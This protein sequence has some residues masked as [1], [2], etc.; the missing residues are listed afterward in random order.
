MAS[1]YCSIATSVRPIGL[2]SRTARRASRARKGTK[3]LAFTTAPVQETAY[4]TKHTGERTWTSDSGAEQGT[5]T[6]SVPVPLENPADDPRLANPL[7][8]FERLGTGWMGVVVDLEGVIVREN[9]EAHMT[10]WQ[11]LSDEERR[12]APLAFALHRAI[13]KKNEQVVSEV[14]CWTRDPTEVRRLARRKH[15]LYL[16]LLGEGYRYEELDGARHLLNLLKKHGVPVAIGSSLPKDHID[17]ILKEL[18]LSSFFD[19]VVSGEDVSRGRPDPECYWYASQLIERPTARCIVIGNDNSCTEAAHDAGMKCVTVASRRP[20]Y[21]LSAADLVVR[22]LDELSLI[23]LKALFSQEEGTE[24][25][26]QLE[27]EADIQTS[28]FYD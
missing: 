1:V 8:R 23:N 13:G 24:P 3:A 10:A 16:E 5:T 7:Q 15:E 25:Q 2:T 21:E 26:L 18:D 9:V 28:F 14:L 19:A 11:K 12:P 6:A 4:S 20:L 27:E 17:V 22:R